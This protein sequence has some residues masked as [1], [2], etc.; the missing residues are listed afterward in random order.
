MMIMI[1]YFTLFSYEHRF[2]ILEIDEIDGFRKE[3]IP[4]IG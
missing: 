2:P 3:P 4:G 1:T